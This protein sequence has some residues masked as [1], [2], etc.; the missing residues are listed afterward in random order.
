MKRIY[1]EITNQ[2]NLTCRT[3]VRNVWGEETGNMSG[4]VFRRILK[5]ALELPSKPEIF[6]GGYG[7]PLSHPDCLAMI[8]RAKSLGLRVSLITNGIMLT[9]AISHSLIDIGLDMLWVSIDGASPES[10]ADVRLGAKLPQV[11]A[12]LERLQ[13]LKTDKFGSSTWVGR[14]LVGLAFVAMKRN[15]KDLPAILELGKRLG[16][17]E[18]NITNV[19]A[20]TAELQ[21]EVLYSQSLY[22]SSSSS[23]RDV[24]PHLNFPRLDAEKLPKTIPN[25]FLP[26]EYRIT[27]ADEAIPQVDNRCPFLERGSVAVRWDGKTSP[28]LPLMHTHVFYLDD[29]KHTSYAY[30]VGD[31]SERGLADIW[32]DPTYTSFRQ[33][34]RAFDFSPCT[35][36][37]SCDMAN[38]NLEDCFG[39]THPACG[40]CLWAQGFIRCP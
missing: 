28:C 18:Y 1:V 26:R 40:A 39:N 25:S 21:E 32:H 24:R 23:D 14:P 4:D 22:R 2:C 29:R 3:C 5:G 31:I 33:R 36:C 30:Q 38:D 10:Y 9:E 20:H 7:E 15:I 34:L 27:L 19:L 37:N 16:V 13:T 35:T 11:I 12:N 17:N 8:E 6:L